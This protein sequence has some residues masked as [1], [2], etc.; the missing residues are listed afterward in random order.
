[1]YDTCAKTSLQFDALSMGDSVDSVTL[2]NGASRESS[3]IDVINSKPGGVFLTS[4][5]E[6]WVEFKTDEVHVASGFQLRISVTSAL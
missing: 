4:S 2:R 1:M 6:L 3:V 5:N